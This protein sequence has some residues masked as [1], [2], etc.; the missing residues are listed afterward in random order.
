MNDCI[1]VRPITGHLL[2][3]GDVHI[4]NRGVLLNSW[5]SS[6]NPTKFLFKADDF[7]AEIPYENFLRAAAES[8][9][10]NFILDVPRRR[11]C[12]VVA[13]NLKISILYLPEGRPWTE[14]LELAE[15]EW[16]DMKD[17]VGNC[18]KWNECWFIGQITIGLTKN[19]AK[20]YDMQRQSNDQVSARET[21]LNALLK[22]ES[23]NS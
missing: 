1:K 9:F 6:E 11:W 14:A 8:N 18:I 20:L 12:E 3:G 16:N 4:D 10:S 22:N 19:L 17:A 2:I 13:Y 7:D 21:I 23:I 15:I 5:L